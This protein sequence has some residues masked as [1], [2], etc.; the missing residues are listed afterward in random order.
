[1]RKLF[2]TVIGLLA[3]ASVE[4]SRRCNLSCGDKYDSCQKQGQ[5]AAICASG[6]TQC[7]ISCE[8]SFNFAEAF[9]SFVEHQDQMDTDAQAQADFNGFDLDKDGY[10]NETEIKAAMEIDGDTVNSNHTKEVISRI[11]ANGDSK[12]DWSEV[13]TVFRAK[14]GDIKTGNS[15]TASLLA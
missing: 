8:K 15:T 1:M 6:F 7:K 13:H 14:D 11:D 2:A 4:A 10:L 9:K 12:L 5:H 3:L